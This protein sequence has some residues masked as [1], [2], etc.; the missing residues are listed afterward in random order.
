MTDMK[1]SFFDKI[2]F[3][4]LN[5]I[6]SK[7]YRTN[8]SR[9]FFKYFF[10]LVR[11]IKGRKVDFGNRGIESSKLNFNLDRYGWGEFNKM[12]LNNDFVISIPKE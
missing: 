6:F 4:L 11:R 3:H 5:K 9:N 8:F 1:N 10:E 12:D 2:I 7:C